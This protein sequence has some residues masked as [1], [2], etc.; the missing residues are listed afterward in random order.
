[1]QKD[2]DE[3]EN[4]GQDEC[5]NENCCGGRA[6]S[7][8]C[9]DNAKPLSGHAKE[10]LDDL[11]ARDLCEMIGGPMDGLKCR[12]PADKIE[13]EWKDA[14]KKERRV[15][16]YRRTMAGVMVASGATAGANRFEFVET[17]IVG[18]DKQ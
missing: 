3:N 2:D 12:L 15:A 10:F 4:E 7:D 14:S 16:V 9:D 6:D 11:S 5:E 17:R 13:V 1:M 8:G 18:K